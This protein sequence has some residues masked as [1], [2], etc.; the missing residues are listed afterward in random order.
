MESKPLFWSGQ[1]WASCGL[2]YLPGGWTPTNLFPFLRCPKCVLMKPADQIPDYA[3]HGSS[4]GFRTLEA[5]K[6]LIA[7]GYMQPAHG[8]KEHL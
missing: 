5:A 4:A 7:G 1:L 3:P 6:L 8:R 2:R